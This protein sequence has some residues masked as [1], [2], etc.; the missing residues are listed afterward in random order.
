MESIF[1]SWSRMFLAVPVLIAL[2]IPFLDIPFR[3]YGFI[4]FIITLGFFFGRNEEIRPAFQRESILGQSSVVSIASSGVFT[5]KCEQV[6]TF[7][8]IQKVSLVIEKEDYFYD[9]INYG[10]PACYPDFPATLRPSHERRTWRLQEEMD[11]VHENIIVIDFSYQTGRELKKLRESG[12]WYFNINGFY[13]IKG[14]KMPT[15]Q[16]LKTL[17]LDVRKF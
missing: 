2:F 11:K 17:S 5:M 13:F 10:C 8:R 6:R 7:A 12:A 4:L 3:R 14:N 16:L 1:F 15:G 9:F